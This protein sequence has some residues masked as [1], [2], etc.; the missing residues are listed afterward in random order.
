MPMERSSLRPG[1]PAPMGG[2]SADGV[3]GGRVGVDAE[4]DVPQRAQLGFEQDLLAR[5]VGLGQVLAHVADVGGKDLGVMLAPGPHLLYA[6]GRLAVDLL[7][8]Q[9]LGLHDSLQA[10]AHATVHMAQIAHTQG[11]F[12]ILSP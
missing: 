6:D 3:G 2:V 8:G 11:L 12:H 5:L 10:L 7:H 1:M 9:V 4:V